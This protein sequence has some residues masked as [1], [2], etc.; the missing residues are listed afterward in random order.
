MF[1]SGIRGR[2]VYLWL[3]SRWFIVGESTLWGVCA[4][5]QYALLGKTDFNDINNEIHR[6]TYTGNPP[7]SYFSSGYVFLLRACLQIQ[8]SVLARRRD[9]FAIMLI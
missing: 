5:R 4:V 2:S 1:V 3:I 8:F 6:I 9:M 7:V